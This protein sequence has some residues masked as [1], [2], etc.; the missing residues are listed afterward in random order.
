MD[1]IRRR[2]GDVEAVEEKRRLVGADPVDAE[3]TVGAPDDG[4][5]EGKGFARV[6]RCRGEPLQRRLRKLRGDD[7]KSRGIGAGGRG[8][9]VHGLLG[10]SERQ[11]DSRGI[12]AWHRHA[13][14]A[15]RRGHDAAP[16]WACREREAAIARSHGRRRHGLAIEQ[17]HRHAR[18]GERRLIDDAVQL[19]GCDRPGGAQQ[20]GDGAEPHDASARHA[21]S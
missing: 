16:G 12:R 1:D 18:E 6:R 4:R 21:C 5:K 10:S 14:E 8:G 9:D 17:L 20:Y 2:I 15:R 3:Q 13:L 7:G 11:D 19:I